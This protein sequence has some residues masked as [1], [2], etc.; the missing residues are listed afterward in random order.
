MLGFGARF[1]AAEDG[2]LSWQILR[3]GRSILHLADTVVIHQGFRDPD[4]FRETVKRDLSGVGGTAAKYLPA[5]SGE[6]GLEMG[7][8]G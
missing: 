5:D 1:G 6:R 2:D 8:H 7:E 4:Q 3:R